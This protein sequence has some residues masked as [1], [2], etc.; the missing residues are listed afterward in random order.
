VPGR[1]DGSPA[2]GVDGLWNAAQKH[3]RNGDV[4]ANSSELWGIIPPVDDV[5]LDLAGVTPGAARRVM[6][7]GRSVV[8]R[9]CWR[10]WRL[11]LLQLS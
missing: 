11:V 3:R 4:L 8:R 7:M 5:A 6:R 1:T 2:P 10:R 9:A